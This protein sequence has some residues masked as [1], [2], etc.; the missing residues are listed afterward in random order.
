LSS[1]CAEAGTHRD[2]TNFL[3][4]LVPPPRKRNR[5]DIEDQLGDHLVTGGMDF[6]MG[7]IM[8]DTASKSLLQHS[9]K[10]NARGSFW[11]EQKGEHEEHL[12]KSIGILS[13]QKIGNLAYFVFF[14][15][16]DCGKYVQAESCG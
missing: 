6:D 13:I 10:S 15:E 7:N 14:A 2:C 12:R 9:D 11:A 8:Q 4:T 1:L 3:I 16:A 5:G